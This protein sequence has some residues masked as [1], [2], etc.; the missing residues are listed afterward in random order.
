MQH[1][2][3][4]ERAQIYYA[5]GFSIRTGYDA[6]LMAEHA[7]NATGKTFAINLSAPYVC[8]HLSDR[9]MQ[10]LPL[11]DI[12]FGNEEEALALAKA[13]NWQVNI[14]IFCFSCCYARCRLVHKRDTPCFTLS[15]PFSHSKTFSNWLLDKWNGVCNFPRL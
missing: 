3:A 8:Q 11:V 14:E 12:V 4:V 6:V 10:L 7:A 1:W 15:C 13:L 9:L 5:A 2:E